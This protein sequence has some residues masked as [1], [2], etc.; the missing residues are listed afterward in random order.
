MFTAQANRSIQ[1]RKLRNMGI[2]LLTAVS[3]AGAASA[4]SYSASKPLRVALVLHGNLG[5]KS[6]FDSANAGMVK[7]QKELP[8]QVKVIEAGTDRARWQPALADAADGPY[9]VIIVGTFE[10]NGFLSKIAPQYPD[11]KFVLYDD[12][13]DYSSNCCVNVYSLNYRTSTA[14]YLAGFAAAKKSKSGK[15]GVILGANGGPILEF[16]VGFKQGAKAANPRIQFLDAVANTFSD[17]AK[18]KELALAQIQQGADVVFP[19]A[20]GTGI[21]VLQA[22]R[23]KGV[24]AIGVD[25]DQA[26]LFEK[27]DPAQ[28]KVILTSVIKNVG[29]S[30][31][32][33]LRDTISGK[34]KYGQSTILGLSDGAVGI[35]ENSYYQSLVSASVRRQIESLKKRIVAGQIK[36]DTALK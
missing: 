28:A 26:S 9:D 33:V 31:F 23:D 17:P 1:S 15:L 20:G 13:V 35:A 8:V 12:S 36:V 5:D 6:I 4:Q 19:I 25:S 18:G 7:A 24:Y 34:A 2:L 29:Q 27:T 14:A 10:M 30:L 22:A 16:A 21:G 11:K 3:L 32:V